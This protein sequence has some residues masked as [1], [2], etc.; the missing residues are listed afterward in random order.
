MGLAPCRE[1]V[2]DELP[3]RQRGSPLQA[4][5]NSFFEP[6]GGRGECLSED[7]HDLRAPADEWVVGE[8]DGQ[9]PLGLAATD[10]SVEPS[11]QRTQLAIRGRT[12]FLED[13]ERT[14]RP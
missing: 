5:E 1:L 9:D 2:R 3:G 10:E 6:F 13:E 11:T 8:R 14:A 7:E 4:A 12:A